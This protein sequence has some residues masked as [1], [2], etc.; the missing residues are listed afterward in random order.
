MGTCPVA[1]PVRSA[2]RE[3]EKKEKKT[4]K[5][6]STPLPGA[7][8]Y[9]AQKML[10]VLIR[11]SLEQ[12]ALFE[13]GQPA[14]RIKDLG[15]ARDLVLVRQILPALATH[16]AINTTSPLPTTRLSNGKWANSRNAATTEGAVPMSTRPIL[17]WEFWRA[18]H[19]DMDD[20]DGKAAWNRLSLAE[21]APYLDQARQ[22]AEAM[23]SR[24]GKCRAA[25]IERQKKKK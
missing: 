9:L 16:C 14:G 20:G 6:K 4:K 24:S 5:R 10:Q 1:E 3:R 23:L 25:A 17:A 18:E 12:I 11:H 22:A 15:L 7:A 13:V 2:K 19:P 8:P 21:R